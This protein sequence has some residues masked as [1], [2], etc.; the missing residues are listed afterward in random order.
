MV[1]KDNEG[2]DAVWRKAAYRE[3]F[4]I[5]ETWERGL[6][7]SLLPRGNSRELT[8]KGPHSLFWDAYLTKKD[9]DL[10]SPNKAK[11]SIQK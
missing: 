5:R 10:K 1:E 2:P 6:S 3:A 8:Y 9:L 4:F 11:N 7:V